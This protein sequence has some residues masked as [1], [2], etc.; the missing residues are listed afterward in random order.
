MAGKKQVSPVVAIVVIVVVIALIVAIY[1]VIGGRKKP[2]AAASGV[3]QPAVQDASQVPSG[4][5]PG[6]QGDPTSK[7]GQMKGP[8]TGDA[9]GGGGGM[10]GG[11]APPPTGN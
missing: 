2:D 8:D 4:Q 9:G 10:Q 1:L 6:M 3:A 11:A 7:M 5:T